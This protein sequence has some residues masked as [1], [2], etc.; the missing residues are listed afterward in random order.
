MRDRKERWGERERERERERE[1]ETHREGERERHRERETERER[2]RDSQIERTTIT[3]FIIPGITI[4]TKKQLPIYSQIKMIKTLIVCAILLACVSATKYCEISGDFYNVLMLD[5][6]ERKTYLNAGTMMSRSRAGIEA[7]CEAMTVDECA[8]IQYD[9][10]SRTYWIRPS[11]V[12]HI[13]SD[14]YVGYVRDGDC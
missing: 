2:E 8:Y 12:P 10:Y 4:V 9:K 14:R 1:K 3:A 5:K 6:E 13:S 7:K 11:N